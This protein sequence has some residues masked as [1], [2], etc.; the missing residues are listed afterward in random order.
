M[1]KNNWILI[2]LSKQL[3]HLFPKIL[4]MSCNTCMCILLTFKMSTNVTQ[5][6]TFA[7]QY[8]IRFLTFFYIIQCKKERSVYSKN[9]NHNNFSC[10]RVLPFIEQ[11][12]FTVLPT[13]DVSVNSAKQYILSADDK[14]DV[15]VSAR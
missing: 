1:C 5:C 14:V 9:N 6:H 15:T 4:G 12:A 11:M 7:E 10:A 2:C 8:S 3:W 13:F